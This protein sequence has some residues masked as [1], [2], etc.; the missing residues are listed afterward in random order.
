MRKAI[1]KFFSQ[2]REKTDYYD[3]NLLAVVILL[4]CLFAFGF[5]NCC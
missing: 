5:M 4:T 2:L 1:G 3:Y